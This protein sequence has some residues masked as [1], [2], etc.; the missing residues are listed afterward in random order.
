[1]SKVKMGINGLPVPELIERAREITGSL[2]GNAN[3][4]TIDSR[5]RDKDKIA[6]MR[7]KVKALKFLLVQLA[8]YVQQASDGDETKILSSGFDVVPVRVPRPDT[9]GVVTNLRLYEGSNSGK[10]KADWN[11]AD[12]AVIYIIE[13]SLTADFAISD[14]KGITTRSQK[15]IG[16]FTPGQRVWIRIVPLGRENPG[17]KSEPASIIVK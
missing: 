2:A 3:F 15:E 7:V 17:P 16:D 5:G 13:F 8:A 10:I 14:S 1:M 6:F 9:A 4:P 11:K 12:Y